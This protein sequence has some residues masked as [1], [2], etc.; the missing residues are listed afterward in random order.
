MARLTG[1]T[2]LHLNDN[3]LSGAIPAQ[4]QG[5]TSLK[6]LNLASNRLSGTVPAELGN[7]TNLTLLYLDNNQLSGELPSQLGNIPN[8]QKV[9][10]WDNNLTWADSYANGILSDTVG[11]VAIHDALLSHSSS[12][13]RSEDWLSYKPLGEWH[14]VTN[15]GGRITELSQLQRGSSLSGTIP[16]EIGLLTGL[17]K[18]DLSNT[19]ELTG[20]IPAS[21]RGVEYEGELPFCN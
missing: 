17:R 15:V 13:W 18:L 7:L 20:C 2:H 12:F 1:L 21:L 5:L 11:L 10:V 16:P 14:R 6:E 19:P 3:G 8:L 9:S 4:L